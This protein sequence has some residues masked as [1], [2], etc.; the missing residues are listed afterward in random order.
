M[1][2][3]KK[4]VLISLI[5]ALLAVYFIFARLVPSI[6]LYIALNEQYKDTFAVYKQ[7]K[8]NVGELENN[9][10]LLKEIA[11]LNAI[12]PDFSTQAPKDFDDE[13][14]LIDLGKFS[15]ETSA[16]LIS[17]TSK[18]PKEIE[19]EEADSTKKDN[20]DNK[21]KGAKKEKSNKG[22]KKG[23][24]KK[25]A[26]PLSIYEKEFEIKTLGKYPEVIAFMQNLENYQR[27]F[28]IQSI[29]A[30]I[31]KEDE[32]KSNPR[33]ELTITGTTYK[34]LKNKIEEKI[35]ETTEEA[36]EKRDK[37]KKKENK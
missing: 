27:K 26:L 35:E 18:K 12:I 32:N 25:E 30:E 3:N 23:K 9:K 10:K 17:L 11:E 31:A 15:E 5:P 36:T 37:D 28:I 21:D 4:F 2:N 34:A 33:V 22:K 7:T 13:Y 1:K 20:K 29:S 16:K 19:I 8:S 14:F 6:N 24:K